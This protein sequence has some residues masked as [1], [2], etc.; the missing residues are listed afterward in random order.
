MQQRR[1]DPNDASAFA[2][3]FDVYHRSEA[4]RDPPERPSWLPE[5]IRARAQDDGGADVTH[6]LSFVDE[7]DTV[8]SVARVDVT[9]D[10]ATWLRA[11][12]HV[13]PPHRRRGVGSAHLALVEEYVRDHGRP[14]IAVTVMEGEHDLHAGAH[15]SFAPRHGYVLADEAA[16]RDL[17]WPRPPG[18][19]DALKESWSAF[20]EGYDIV[21]WNGRTPD[22]WVDDRVYLAEVM[23]L[24]APFGDLSPS[25]ESWDLDRL[26]RLE[27]RVDAMGRDYLVAVA[28]HRA[29][30]HLVGFSELT[31][32]RET[33]Q[34]AYQWDTLVLTAHR[35]HRLGGLMKLATMDL[36]ETTALQVREI[37]TFNSVANVPMIRVNKQLGARLTGAHVTW[38]KSLDGPTRSA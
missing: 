37:S 20:A 15:R 5:E 25:H 30:N 17:L 13:D 32:S 3:W 29:S 16:R 38:R 34:I 2:A 27:D 9:R 4:L 36:L 7:T 33:P 24:E 35:G 23:P 26:R 22:R 21:S 11:E 6:L 8:L 18:E 14:E 10:N 1:V 19:R 31:V 28:R 12:V